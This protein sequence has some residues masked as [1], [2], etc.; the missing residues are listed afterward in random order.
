[1]NRV[2]LGPLAQTD[3][4]GEYGTLTP[5]SYWSDFYIKDALLS[6]RFLRQYSS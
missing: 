5:A 3:V 6:H 4:S 1:M 2:A